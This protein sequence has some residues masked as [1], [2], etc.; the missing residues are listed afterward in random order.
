MLVQHNAHKTWLIGDP[1]FGRDFRRG[2]PIARR[3]ERE[4]MQRAAFIAELETEE[5][6]T[7][8]MVGDLFDKPVVPLQILSQVISDVLI[9]ADHRPDVQFIFMAGNHDLSRQLGVKG[10]WDIFTLAVGWMENIVIVEGGPTLYQDVLYF[11]WDWT[12]T[13][14]EQIE[15]V[16][17]VGSLS[18]VVGHWDMMTF[19]GDDSHLCPVRSLHTKFGPSVAIYS[20]HYHEE[21]DYEIDGVTVHCTGSLQPYAHGEGDMYVTL[22]AEEALARDDLRNKCV[23]IRLQ[24]GEVMPEIDCLQ[25]TSIRVTTEDEESEVHLEAVG[26]AS[27]NVDETLNTNLEEAKVPETIRIYIKEKLGVI[28]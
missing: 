17:E 22:T 26:A 28:N 21:K 12:M 3:G 5:V 23:R 20:G 1:H 15:M 2:T 8:V 9:T 16:G 11:P 14:V 7:I 27:F 4:I 19:G 25:L 6:D 13:A 18:A 10:A 24:P